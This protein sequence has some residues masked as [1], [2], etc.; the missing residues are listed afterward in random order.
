VGAFVRVRRIW[1]ALLLAVWLG[2][3]AVAEDLTVAAAADLNY[4]MKDMASRFEQKTGAKV[5]LSFG[6]SGNF[7]SQIQSGAPFDLF[8]SADAEYPEKLAA[9]GAMDGSSLRTYAVGHL[10]LWVP[11]S[12]GLDPQ[13]LKA[14]L[15]LE[16]AIQKIAIANPEH[17]PY[18]RAAMAA[19]QTLGLKNKVRDK[20]VLGE[21]VS[22]AAQFVQS[23][24]AQAGLMPLSL[25]ISPPMK[26]AG[27]YWEIPA[28]DY[29]EI[30]QE[31]G[32]VSSSKHKASAQ[33]FL[34]FVASPVGGAILRQYGFALPSR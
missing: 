2:T 30:D 1:L 21:N 3:F 13:N 16:A 19:L 6:A 20:L 4:A 15:L 11:K 18:G 29:P 26:D 25:A 10:V 34:D 12:S 14:N 28:E 23:G 32:I 31:A 9:A 22:Q 5:K 17:A 24:N 27:S 8:F 33:A 7:Y